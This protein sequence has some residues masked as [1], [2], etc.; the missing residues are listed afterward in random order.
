MRKFLSLA[1]PLGGITTTMRHRDPARDIRTR[2]ESGLYRHVDWL[3]LE[4]KLWNGLISG[5]AYFW[6]KVIEMLSFRQKLDLH[7]LRERY[8]TCLVQ[9]KVFD[10]LSLGEE[11]WTCLSFKE[12]LWI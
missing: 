6:G 2:S 9:G 3:S 11:L 4:E 5:P 10:L 1:E 8:W 7:S 12:R